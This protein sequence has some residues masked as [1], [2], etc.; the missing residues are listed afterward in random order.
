MGSTT[1]PPRPPRLLLTTL[2]TAARAASATTRTQPGCAA[3]RWPPTP[4]ATGCCAC[5]TCWAGW[6]EV[7]ERGGTAPPYTPYANTRY[8]YDGLDQLTDVWD[9]AGNHTEIVYDQA[10]RKKH[11]MTDPDMGTWH[12]GYDQ[13]GN[14]TTQVDALAGATCTYY[15]QF[16][17]LTQKK[18][19]TGVASRPP[20]PA[21]PASPATTPASA[22]TRARTGWA[23]L[24]SQQ[25][26]PTLA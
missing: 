15:D 24:H 7:A 13:A 21:R 14:L 8:G 6:T 22:T 5:T 16:N 3:A 12:Y 26:T 9:H 18:F 2:P 4:T 19:V 20:T 11:R 17:R 10:G 23:A 1:Y 25:R